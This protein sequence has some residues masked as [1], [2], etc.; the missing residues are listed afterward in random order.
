MTLQAQMKVEARSP[1]IPAPGE[2]EAER[3]EAETACPAPIDRCQ[4]RDEQV[5]LNKLIGARIRARRHEQN[6]SLQALAAK[7][8]IGF[9]QIYKYEVGENLIPAC[10]I[11]A[12][13]TMLDVKAGY[14]F[15]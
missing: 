13:A 5:R 12:I 11:V 14:F 10:R 8:G 1:A 3:T 7:L 2:P 4:A 6:L 15:E 9:Q